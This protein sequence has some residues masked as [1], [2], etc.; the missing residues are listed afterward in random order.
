MELGSL[1]EWFTACA[2]VLAVC[3]A[4]FLPRYQ[5]R[6][7]RR[8]SLARMRRVT[9]GLL[10]A[11]ADDRERCGSDCEP[12]KLQSAEDLKLY[13]RISFFALSA[14]QELA[15]RDD[16]ARLYRRLL[17][18]DV[19]LASVRREIAALRRPRRSA[20]AAGGA[21]AKAART[22]AAGRGKTGAA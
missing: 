20:A 17:A 5:A 7:E 6:K 8:A 3:T 18:P 4:L 12:A 22:A 21:H 2:E 1:P 16:V 14:E 19:D 10:E 15:L 9:A 11:L 13:L